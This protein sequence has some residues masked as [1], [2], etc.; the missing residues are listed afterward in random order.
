[1]INC[2]LGETD[3]PECKAVVRMQATDVLSKISTIIS[4]LF[5]PLP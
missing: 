4:T 2:G 1:M 3:S 5:P